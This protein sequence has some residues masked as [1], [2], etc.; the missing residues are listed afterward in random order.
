[1]GGLLALLVAGTATKPGDDRLAGVF[2]PLKSGQLVD[3]VELSNGYQIIFPGTITEDPDW[4]KLPPSGDVINAPY[5]RPA[6]RIL[7]V[8]PEFIVVLCKEDSLS[9]DVEFRIPITSIKSVV[10]RS[11][12]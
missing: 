1:M 7:E 5:V 9:R 6:C 12:R 10:V 11:T 8:R 3:L 2:G 4:A